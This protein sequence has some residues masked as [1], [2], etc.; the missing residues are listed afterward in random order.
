[1]RYKLYKFEY[2]WEAEEKGLRPCTEEGQTV[3]RKK[4]RHD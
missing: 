2:V 4:D 3:D 1:M